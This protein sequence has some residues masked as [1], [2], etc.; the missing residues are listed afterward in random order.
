MKNLLFALTLALLLG[1]CEDPPIE[2]PNAIISFEMDTTGMPKYDTEVAEVV[3]AVHIYDNPWGYDGIKSVV[4]GTAT[5]IELT[6]FTI[7]NIYYLCIETMALDSRDYTIA[8]YIFEKEF[9]LKNK[10]MKFRCNYEGE[11]IP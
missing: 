5:E 8:W 2:N 1:G 11:I 3:L 10:K 6:Q 4:R 7:G 9:V